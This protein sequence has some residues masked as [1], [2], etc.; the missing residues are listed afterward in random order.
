MC[1]DMHVT[2]MSHHGRAAAG[3]IQLAIEWCV[4]VCRRDRERQKKRINEGQTPPCTAGHSLTFHCFHFSVTPFPL[5]PFPSCNL[6]LH[7]YLFSGGVWFHHGQLGLRSSHND[8]RTVHLQPQGG[9]PHLP[10]L[11]RRHRVCFTGAK[12]L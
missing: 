5:S 10:G 11:P 8:W 12:L 9:G 7:F 4:R 6:S 1:M 3:Y 2:Q